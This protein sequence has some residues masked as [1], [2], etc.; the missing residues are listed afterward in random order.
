MQQTIRISGHPPAVSWLEYFSDVVP[1]GVVF[2]CHLCGEAWMW[3]EPERF[4]GYT[5]V[6]HCCAACGNGSLS[7]IDLAYREF[8]IPDELLVREVELRSTKPC[9]F[10]GT[11]Y[12]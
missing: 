4:S 6:T 9:N 2:V 7:T 11:I 12:A 5:S 10:R 8:G 3:M 1:P